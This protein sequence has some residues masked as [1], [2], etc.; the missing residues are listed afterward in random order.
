MAYANES[1][2]AKLLLP[3]SG[4]TVL[5]IPVSLTHL[6]HMT[7]ACPDEYQQPEHCREEPIWAMR[8]VISADGT[9][10]IPVELIAPLTVLSNVVRESRV[11][12]EIP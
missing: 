4:R 2:S 3:S 9:R 11:K 10:L 7:I 5:N 12:L 6:A 1:N 8:R